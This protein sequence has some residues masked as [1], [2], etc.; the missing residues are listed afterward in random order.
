MNALKFLKYFLFINFILLLFGI[1]IAP[2]FLG[3]FI[4][5]WY[6]FFFVLS[7]FIDCLLAGAAL[8]IIAISTEE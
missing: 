4:S 3:L 2:L 7:F 5:P 1:L 6:F 8:S